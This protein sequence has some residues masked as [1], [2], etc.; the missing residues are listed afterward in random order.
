MY[1]YEIPLH[2]SSYSSREI[3][4]QEKKQQ[5]KLLEAKKEYSEFI[6]NSKNY[7]LSESI[8]MILQN[9]LDEDTSE[10]N[11]EYGKAL[12]EAF[13]NENTSTKLLT[14]FAK[15]TLLLANISCIVNEAHQKV[16]HDSK[17]GDI[18]T[19]RISKT[20]DSE[21]FDK[22][23]GLSDKRITDTINQRVC[24]SIESFVQSNIN[25]K[26]DLDELAEKT[27]EKID[28]IRAKSEEQRKA[29]VK[30]FTNQYNM[31]VQRIKQKTN[32]KIGLYEQIM[33][34]FTHDI[35]SDKSILESF[36]QEDGKLDV[37][38]IQGK[39]NVLY[40][41]LE[42]LNTTKMAKVDESYLEKIIN[43]K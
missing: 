37:N 7:F 24:D 3:Y 43:K 6:A 14:E 40:T 12:V 20:V 28:N 19:F 41:F 11:R 8:N 2:E 18:K 9:S 36:T 39:V 38:K 23:V 10:E 21:F 17:E 15:K 32:R 31:Q 30:E 34:N 35:V 4:Q 16:I 22:L 26:L 27:K 25:D 1:E 42:M 13:V 29:M 33:N 5:Q